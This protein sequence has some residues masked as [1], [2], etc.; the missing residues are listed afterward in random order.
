[1]RARNLSY[2]KIAEF[3]GYCSRTIT[4]FIQKHK[5]GLTTCLT[6]QT[7]LR[8]PIVLELLRTIETLG[9]YLKQ[10]LAGI[11][12]WTVGQPLCTHEGGHLALWIFKAHDASFS[13]EMSW[14]CQ[15]TRTFF[16][17]YSNQR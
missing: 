4:S 17:S 11:A 8:H 12:T 5:V 13:G 14:S 10:L 6:K 16:Q 15:K 9:H 3:T 1:M 7:Y 2:D